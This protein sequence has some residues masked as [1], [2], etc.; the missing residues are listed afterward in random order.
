MKNPLK[1]YLFVFLLAL[2]FDAFST[3]LPPSIEGSSLVNSG[4]A[5]TYTFTESW[6]ALPTWNIISGS[7][8]INS[9]WSSGTTY[10]AS[11]TWTAS[12]TVAF[13]DDISGAYAEKAISVRGSSISA[14]TPIHASRCG[15]GTVALSAA[16]GSGG[17]KVLW[18]TS[19]TGGTHVAEGLTYTTPSI[20]TTTTYYIVTWNS[21]TSQ[22][23]I[24]RTP[25]TAT[26][27]AA[28]NQPTSSTGGTS[29][30][31]A[32]IT[33]SAVPGSGGN[34]IVWYASPVGDNIAY[35]GTSFTT[36]VLTTSTTYYA[37]SI[38]STTGC[39]STRIPVLAQIN[40]KPSQT[41]AQQLNNIY[42]SGTTGLKAYLYFG[43]Y[44]GAPT[45]VYP[46]DNTIIDEV[47]FEVKWYATEANALAGTSSLYTG[48]TF[49]TPT[50]SAT[51][52]YYVRI[53]DKVT[54]CLGDVSEVKAV[55][56]PLIT[57]AKIQSD[58]IRVTGKKNEAALGGLNNTQKST[59]IVYLDGIGRTAQQIVMA[60]SQLGKD[61]VMPV[62]Y[63]NLGRSSKNYL[64]YVDNSSSNGAFKSSYVID[65]LN[66]YQASGDKIAND[67]S[68]FAIAKFEDTPEGR[69][70]EQGGV[71][72]VWQPGTGHTTS[73][74][75]SFN[76]GSTNSEAEEVR[77]FNSDASSTGFYAANKL[78]RLESTDA[79]GNKEIVFQNSL[80][81]TIAKKTQLDKTTEGVMVNYIQTYYCYNEV[82]Q[83]TYIIQ[84]KGIK[85]LKS[86][87]WNITQAI[88]D[89]HMFQYTYDGRGRVISKKVPGSDWEY[90]V[91]DQMNRPVLTQDANTRALNKWNFIKYDNKGRVV[92]TGLYTDAVNTTRSSLQAILDLKNYDGSDKYFEIRKG[93]TTHGYSNQAFPISNIQITTVNYYDGHDFNFDGTQDYAYAPQSLPNEGTT[94]SSSFG[95]STGSKILIDD[96]TGSKWKISYVFHDS[97]GRVI[98]TKSNNHLNTNSFGNLNTTV[99]DFEKV[100][101]SKVVHDDGPTTVTIINRPVY[102]N[103]TGSLTKIY[104]SLNG[105]AELLVAQ[106]QYNDLGQLVDKK[107]HGTGTQ[108]SETFLQSVDYRY[109]INGQLLSI[110]NAQLT[111]GENN[112]ETNDYF[113]MELMYN[114]VSDASLGNTARFDGSVSAI[115][116]KAAGATSGAEDQRSYKFSYDKSNKLETA[117]SQVRGATT[118]N[119]EA[120]AQNE[121]M[122]YDLNGNVKTLLRYQRKHQLAGVVASYTSDQIDNLTYTYNS[123]NANLLDKVTDASQTIGFNNGSSGTST[124]YT[125][126]SNGSIKSDLNKGISL[127]TYN[128]LGKT[129]RID[130]TDGRKIE[131]L[132]D[133]VGN[134]LTMKSFQG[135]TLLMTTDYV[136]GFVYENN[137]LSFFGSPEGRV[138]KKAVYLSIN[139]PLPTIREIQG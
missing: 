86:A 32:A 3:V 115:K 5:Y 97:Y 106:Y 79:M 138:V 4:V 114:D 72:S 22:G 71:G 101:R 70:I 27:N 28:V 87:S 45:S 16:L 124:D 34:N 25:I 130:F 33:I 122:T 109:A 80:G 123:T 12:G 128:H 43:S 67:V 47:K 58:L 117:T 18:Y 64:P 40:E 61:I 6:V 93:S 94:A 57:S 127:I 7:A 53:R 85:A 46:E 29:C 41:G 76:T 74:K 21:S 103:I 14:P 98:Q 10:Y 131:Y 62:A 59:T 102:D 69:L 107:L 56:I 49:T 100:T 91:Y 111:A 125:Y 121:S 66:F 133:A 19:L 90:I 48:V 120:N 9:T 132:Y 35:T 83:V 116:W 105:G 129:T 39:T 137:A 134:K 54:N 38:N 75:Y 24:P 84:P 50:L 92:M 95:R 31:P 55:V 96:G 108:G 119:K 110:N 118:W 78:H 51:K 44:D 112:D 42:G 60:G 20:S 77:K 2:N 99:Y 13:Y 30:G 26:V 73:I 17:D 15:A 82:G 139:M 52:T 89:Q 1:K 88:R 81:Q 65:Q 37:A 68:P 126:Y 36:P 135:T 63:D 8:T 136:N 113:G 11:I 104:Q 23:S